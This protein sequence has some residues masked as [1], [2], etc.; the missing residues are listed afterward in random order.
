[1]LPRPF[2]CAGKR[3]RTSFRW[4]GRPCSS[5]RC[6]GTPPVPG[7][8]ASVLFPPRVFAGAVFL[9]AS[10]KMLPGLCFPTKPTETCEGPGGIIRAYHRFLA[11]I[12]IQGSGGEGGKQQQGRLVRFDHWLFPSSIKTFLEQLV[13]GA[14]L[15]FAEV[16]RILL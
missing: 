7:F 14:A 3:M 8:A 16:Q 4:P 11:I 15:P 6:D 12:K 10:W 2:A 13:G 1:M 5:S 9:L